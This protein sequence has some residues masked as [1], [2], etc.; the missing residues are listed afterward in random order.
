MNG[1]D[2]NRLNGSIKSLRTEELCLPRGLNQAEIERLLSIVKNHYS[3]HR[4]E[5]VF[6]KGDKSNSIFAVKSGVVKSYMP[7]D[8]GEEHV[9]GFHLSR[10]LFGFDA[11]GESEFPYAAVALETAE[12]CELPISRLDELCRELTGL[13]EVMHELIG[14]EIASEHMML[15][16]LGK[17]SA[18]TRLASFLFNLS[19]RMADR[20]YS[21][22]EFELKM[23]RRDIGNYLGLAEETVSRLFTRLQDEKVITAARRHIHIDDMAKLQKIA[24]I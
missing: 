9:L 6:H 22:K 2:L 19:R 14:K 13:R 8:A 4:G 23:S 18:E 16:M 15:L 20:G 10:E 7:T 17:K 21:P 3:L 5:H 11:F 24:E 1:I 12:V